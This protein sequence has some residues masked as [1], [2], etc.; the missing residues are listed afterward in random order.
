M[1]FDVEFHEMV[2]QDRRLD[3]RSTAKSIPDGRD[4]TQQLD[5]LLVLK[6][7]HF[8]E[9]ELAQRRQRQ[10]EPRWAPDGT[11]GERGTVVARHQTAEPVDERDALSLSCVQRWGRSARTKWRRT[12]F[13]GCR[14]VD[15]KAAA[16]V[17]PRDTRAEV[18]NGRSGRE[19][20]LASLREVCRRHEADDAVRRHGRDQLLVCGQGRGSDAL[21]RCGIDSNLRDLLW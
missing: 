3:E 21:A 11:R 14:V 9:A 10:Q 6:A 19:T 7:V 8:H 20:V 17:L 4:V 15:R 12:A 13:V 18:L 2:L 16:V 5:V 1:T